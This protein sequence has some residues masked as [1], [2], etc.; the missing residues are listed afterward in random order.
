ME[1]IKAKKYENETATI[2]IYGETHEIK[3]PKNGQE[4][5]FYGKKYQLQL[6]E[7]KQA[8]KESENERNTNANAS[9]S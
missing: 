8:P 9:R 7:P 5:E 1:I 4:L 6:E 2:E 3:N